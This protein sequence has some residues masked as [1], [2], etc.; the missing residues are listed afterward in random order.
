[1]NL[2]V[3][4]ANDKAQNYVGEEKVAFLFKIFK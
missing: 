4:K 3:L 1:M 2:G